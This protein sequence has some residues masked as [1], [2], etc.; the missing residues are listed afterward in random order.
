MN[1]QMLK[2]L[3][4]KRGRLVGGA[5]L[6]RLM[7]DAVVW[8]RRGKASSRRTLPTQSMTIWAASKSWWGQIRRDF[9]LRS[10]NHRHQNVGA[11]RRH[12][13]GHRVWGRSSRPVAPTRLN[14]LKLAKTLILKFFLILK[15]F[16]KK[17]EIEIVKGRNTDKFA[18]GRV[19]ACL[20][21]GGYK[22][23][24]SETEV[25]WGRLRLCIFDWD[26]G[27][28]TLKRGHQTGS[29]PNAIVAV[30][31]GNALQLQAGFWAFVRAFY[32]E[33]I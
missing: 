12:G 25:V 26:E 23:F 20:F 24:G 28:D 13:L 30:L 14:S 32:F 21:F 8:D 31:A 7:R 22:I 16:G 9:G 3:M 10:A 33:L 1:A 4:T 15:W 19:C 11:A 5:A 27:A 29:C 18:L 2:I 6:C 17:T